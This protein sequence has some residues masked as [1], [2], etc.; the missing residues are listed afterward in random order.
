MKK[1]KLLALI[2]ILALLALL[3]AGIRAE[4]GSASERITKNYTSVSAAWTLSPYAG[5]KVEIDTGAATLAYGEEV[6]LPVTVP[7]DGLY[8][9]RFGYTSMDDSVLPI[10]L[11]LRV[12]GEYPYY[13]CRALTFET[14]WRRGAELTL[15]RYGDEMA[16]PPEKQIRSETKY[17]SDASG[18]RS[19]P[20]VLPLPAGEHEL[21]LSSLEG[22]VRLDFLTLEAPFAAP[23]HAA[24]APAPGDGLITLQGELFDETNDSSIHGITEYDTAVDPCLTGETRLNILD[25]DSLDTAGQSVSWRFT[26]PEDGA[27]H[28]AFNYL[29]SDKTDFPVFADL[30]V[31]GVLPDAAFADRP[32]DYSPSWQRVTVSDDD[33]CPLTL[34]LSAGEHTLT[35]RLSAAPLREALETLDRVTAAVND[36]SLE[37][38]RVAGT[39][40]DKYRD[41]SLSRYIPGLTETLT[42]YAEQLEAL[43]QQYVALSS[44]ENHTAILSGLLVAAKQ[45]RSLA[46]NPDEIPYRV[47]ELATGASSVN[48]CLANVM[49]N[50]L[51]NSLGIDR[52]WLFQEGA[53]LPDAPG[54]LES[55][56]MNVSRFFTSFTDRSWSA[57]A[58]DPSHLQVWVNRSSQYMQIMQKMIDESFTP[59]TGI[60]VDLSIMPDQYKLVLANSSGKA[61]DVAT[62]INYTVPYELA[63]RGALK[64]LT[65][66]EDFTDVASVYG[67]GYF[68][69]GTIGDGIYSMPETLNFWVLFYRTDI[70][71]KLGLSVPE[72]MDDVID[73]LPELQMRGL[74]FYYATAGMTSMRNFHGTTPLLVQHGGSLY[75]ATAAE[76]TALGSRASVDGFTALT[77]LFT[78]YN[79]PVNVDNFYQHFRNGDLPL[80]IADFGAYNMIRNAAPELEGSWKIALIP[81]TRQ[82]DGS[83]D[84]TTCGCADATVIFHNTPE[85]EDMAWQFMRWWSSTEVQ[86][87]FGRTVQVTYGDEYLWATA[88]LEAFARLPWDTAD[89]NIILA[90][91][92]NVVDV[93][94]VP[95]TYL[96]ERE[97]SNAFNDITVNGANEQT[98]LDKAVKTI[99]REIKRKLEEFGFIDADGNVIEEY[100]I[101]TVESVSI[102]L[103]RP[104]EGGR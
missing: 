8:F 15:D 87:E 9:L 88:N 94:R 51:E 39:N 23:A 29:Q 49:D 93:A 76:G 60:Q 74:N 72:T 70:L 20:L 80:G 104:L 78:I 59:Q 3:P 58:A 71:D 64:D 44:G 85:R 73:L 99:D 65:E 18:R 45:L 5:E 101:P 97:M 28:L 33:A 66:F 27:W 82:S 22:T 84:R 57:S 25:P 95:G 17:L 12:D 55:L 2:P 10:R 43:E 16:T 77:D 54:F 40:A 24:P 47:G 69:T 6:S 75:G 41:L 48:Q 31:D 11:S 34:S 79:M 30:L 89:K 46:E 26:V 56:G 90:A 1:R 67:P 14:T 4:D 21:T 19:D 92:K 103:D 50:L 38:T 83:I 100:R 91:A 102:L 98:R 36:L 42:A 96:L 37:I 61:P 81:G 52:V 68:L 7:E 13:E 86:A 32:F 63:I 53:S 62:G 35:L